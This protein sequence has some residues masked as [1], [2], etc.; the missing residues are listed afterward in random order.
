MTPAMLEPPSN[1]V[2]LLPA[3][4]RYEIPG[5]VTETTTERRIVFSPEIPGRRIA[6]AR[7]EWEVLCEAI[8]RAFPE[9]AALLSFADTAEIRREIARAVPLYAGIETLARKGDQVQ[10]GGPTLYEDGT[11]ATPDGKARFFA[12]TP[13][14][15]DAAGAVP[16]ARGNGASFLLS[17]RRGS[18]FNSMVWR[19][20]DPLTS[21]G[22]NEVLISEEDV[23]R[24]GL[25]EGERVVLRSESGSLELRVR[26]APIKP[27]NLEVHWPEAMV[28]LPS[29]RLDSQSGEPDYNARVVLERARPAASSVAAAG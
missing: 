11:F 17:T 6:Q 29:G 14:R 22:R 18:Q 19:E 9:R 3:T 13:P 7:P 20:R 28:L 5:G 26:P 23:V 10:W 12:V 1:A 24:C 16:A 25:I 8:Q 4:T 21:A 27:G 15:A 2:L